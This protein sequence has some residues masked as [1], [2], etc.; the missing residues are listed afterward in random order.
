MG[1]WITKQSSSYGHPRICYQ[2]CNSANHRCGSGFQ[3]VM[4]THQ[5][6][7]FLSFSKIRLPDVLF[8]PVLIN[9][10]HSYLIF[11]FLSISSLEWSF[12]LLMD[13]LSLYK[14]HGPKCE[15]QIKNRKL[16]VYRKIQ[17]WTLLIRKDRETEWLCTRCQ[18]SWR[19]DIN[20]FYI[21]LYAHLTKWNYCSIPW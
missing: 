18:C 7:I 3:V 5:N 21:F 10:S 14:I 12:V 17:T 11:I 15:V 1:A 20:I 4:M 16:R 8:I 6:V 13:I 19:D 9:L 2:F